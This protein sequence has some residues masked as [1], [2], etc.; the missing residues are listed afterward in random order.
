MMASKMHDV[1]LVDANEFVAPQS[2]I[3]GDAARAR[4]STF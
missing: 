2:R 1:F 4:R 3:A